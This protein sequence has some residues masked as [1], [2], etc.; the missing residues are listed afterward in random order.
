MES[1]YSKFGEL[2]Q[3]IKYYII[4]LLGKQKVE[5]L[6]IDFCVDRKRFNTRYGQQ[7]L[8]YVGDELDLLDFYLALNLA[9]QA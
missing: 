4:D 5:N 9:V 3:P 1:T 2:Q 8:I 7:G 6:V